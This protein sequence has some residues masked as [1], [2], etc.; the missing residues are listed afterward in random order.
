MS[1]RL[2]A[3]R[4]ESYKMLEVAED[5]YQQVIVHLKLMS[6]EQKLQALEAMEQLMSSE[7]WCKFHFMKGERERGTN[8]EGEVEGQTLASQRLAEVQTLG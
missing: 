6:V 7:E 1:E 5:K 8:L 4:L 3:E 2:V